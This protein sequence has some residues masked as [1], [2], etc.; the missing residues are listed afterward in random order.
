MFTTAGRDFSARSAKPSGTPR[1]DA[2]WLKLPL[3]PTASS[4]AK[5]ADRNTFNATLLQQAE[6]RAAGRSPRHSRS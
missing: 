6:N 5:T 2:I 4:A 3:K 1:A